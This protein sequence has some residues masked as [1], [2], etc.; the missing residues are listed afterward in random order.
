M[1]SHFGIWGSKSFMNLG[2]WKPKVWI[3]FKMT[4][5]ID[6]LKGRCISRKGQSRLHLPKSKLRKMGSIIGQTIGYKGV[7]VLRGLG[8]YPAK[9]DSSN[10]PH[11][12]VVL[13]CYLALKSGHHCMNNNRWSDCPS[14]NTWLRHLIAQKL[15]KLIIKWIKYVWI[16]CT[17]I[18]WL[19]LAVRAIILLPFSAP[20]NDSSSDSIRKFPLSC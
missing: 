18:K 20:Y 9:I 1:G 2:I 12:M 15:W 17:G 10:P 3:H 19:S 14:Q 13:K 11:P 8:Q 5:L 6:Q 16:F 7:G 4:D